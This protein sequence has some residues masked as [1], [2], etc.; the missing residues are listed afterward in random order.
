M[1]LRAADVAKAGKR[2]PETSEEGSRPVLCHCEY[3]FFQKPVWA[4]ARGPSL[5]RLTLFTHQRRITYKNVTMY[6]WVISTSDSIDY[7]YVLVFEYQRLPDGLRP[8]V[9]V[10]EP[11]HAAAFCQVPA[12]SDILTSQRPS[13]FTI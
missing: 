12:P 4:S 7:N 10:P 1:R 3:I 5:W 11:V 8:G 9:R 2:S 13:M 6:S